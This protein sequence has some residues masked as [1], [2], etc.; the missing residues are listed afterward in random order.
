MVGMFGEE[1]ADLTD[2]NAF[3]QIRNSLL[4]FGSV[5]VYHSPGCRLILD[6]DGLIVARVSFANEFF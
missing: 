3:P 6:F 2:S 1:K 4:P 5:S